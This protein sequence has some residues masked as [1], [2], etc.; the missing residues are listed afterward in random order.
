MLFLLTFTTGHGGYSVIEA[1]ARVEGRKSEVCDFQHEAIVD[2]TVAALQTTVDEHLTSVK[3]RHTLRH[4]R[5]VRIYLN[6][7][8]IPAHV[9]YVPHLYNVADE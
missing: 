4:S 2:H 1:C 5:C 9:P 7:F 3:K 6:L 8:K